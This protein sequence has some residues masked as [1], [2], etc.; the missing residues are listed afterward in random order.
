MGDLFEKAKNL[1]A[2]AAESAKDAGEIGKYKVEIQSKKSDI[3]D[4]M[5]KIGQYMY[6]KYQDEGA[7]KTESAVLEHA[8]KIDDLN[9]AIKDLQDKIEAVKAD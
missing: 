2:K 6:S 7:E 5:V 4:E 1:G 9:A 8:K 3:N